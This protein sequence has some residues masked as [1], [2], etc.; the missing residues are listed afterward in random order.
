MCGIKKQIS[1]L[2]FL[3]LSITSLT[4][5]ECN[6]ELEFLKETMLRT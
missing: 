4:M 5:S 2:A 3:K 1:I 6:G